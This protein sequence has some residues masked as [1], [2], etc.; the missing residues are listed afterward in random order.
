VGW[1]LVL[2][3]CSLLALDPA[4]SVFQYNCRSW[5]REDGLP[6]SG[7][8]A[9]TQ[10][11]DGFLWVGTQKGLVRFDGVEFKPL[12]L[13]DESQFRSPVISALSSS[14]KGGVWFGI[15]N[16]SFGFYNRTTGLSSP[17]GEPWMGPTMNVTGIREVSDGSVWISTDGGTARWVGGDTNQTQFYSDLKIGSAIC[18]GSR[19]R[20]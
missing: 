2:L 5:T 15:R 17:Q 10:T 3:P 11:R 6:A 18:E 13:S 20:V 7:I 4:K 19:G 12:N 16:G 14:D 1:G 8:N 9:I